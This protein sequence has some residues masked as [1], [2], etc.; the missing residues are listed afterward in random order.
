[1]IKPINKNVLLS[2]IEEKEEGGLHF[3]TRDSKTKFKVEEVAKDCEF[4]KKGDVVYVN[5]NII[6]S[7]EDL[8][9]VAEK[10]IIAKVE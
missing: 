9:T 4:V 2:K 5:E 7:L 8:F 1:M 6:E 3:T 10:N